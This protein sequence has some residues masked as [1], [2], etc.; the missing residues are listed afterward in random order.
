MENQL[1]S[2]TEILGTYHQCF[3]TNTRLED[4][5]SRIKI[6]RFIWIF[7]VTKLE[8]R[9]ETSTVG[10]ILDLARLQKALDASKAD[11]VFHLAAQPIVRESY[12]NPVDT[13]E[14]NIM[15]TVNV[16][17]SMRKTSSVKVGIMMTS[18]KCYENNELING[19]I[20]Q[21]TR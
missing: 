8:E 3:F 6:S 5:A 10:D 7:T 4:G 17:E 9:L 14:S 1:K 21:K 12:L 19:K 15:G 16:L 2:L 13:F 18:D 11:V 20:T